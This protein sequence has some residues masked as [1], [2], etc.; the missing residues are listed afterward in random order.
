M[1]PVNQGIFPESGHKI[2]FTTQN[3][4]KTAVG[5]TIITGIFGPG[6]VVTVKPGVNELR[7]PTQPVG[8]DIRWGAESRID[9]IKPTLPERNPSA[10]ILV[11]FENGLRVDTA[12]PKKEASDAAC[13]CMEI[14]GQRFFGESVAVP[15]QVNGERAGLVTDEILD[16]LDHDLAGYDFTSRYEQL[17]TGQKRVFNLM[18]FG[19]ENG[20]DDNDETE[21]PQVAGFRQRVIEALKE[22]GVDDYWV[23]YSNGSLTRDKGLAQALKSA[24]SQF[25]NSQRGEDKLALAHTFKQTLIS[26][27]LPASLGGR[28]GQTVWMRDFGIMVNTL[29][30]QD[31]ARPGAFSA[32]LNSLFT[33]ASN[34]C[35]NGLIPQVVIPDQLLGEFIYLRALGGDSGPGW[36]NQLQAFLQ[37]NYPDAARRLPQL[38]A[39]ELRTLEPSVVKERVEGLKTLF[40]EISAKAQ[41]DGLPL[42]GPSH[43]LRG[44]LN[45]TLATL[46]PGTTDSEIHFIRSF[47]KLLDLADSDAQ[48]DQVKEMI[49]SLARAM[50]YLDQQV[51][52]PD[53]GLPQGSDNR[54]MLD[55][56][57]VQK[58]LCSNAC[59]LLQGFSGLVRHFDKI[60]SDLTMALNKHYQVG[61]E[62][63][64]RFISALM[65]DGVQAQQALE[66]FGQQIKN[67]FIYPEGK[68]APLDFVNSEH[69]VQR[70][71][72]PPEGY[73]PAL[74]EQNKDFLQGKEVNLQGLALAI[75]LGLVDQADHPAAVELIRSQLT[76]AG[77]KAFSP[78]NMGSDYEV[79]LLQKSQGFLV[80]PQIESRVIHVLKKQMDETPAIRDLLE[81]LETIHKQ[82][83]GFREWYNTTEPGG[84]HPGGAENQS[85]HITNLVQA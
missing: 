79:D 65:Q 3:Q 45:N 10:L 74:V 1:T 5:K 68:F 58:L 34:Q 39:T 70:Q 83:P 48:V 40:R 61:Q 59:F 12:S 50:V 21:T 20:I 7:T 71:P 29:N 63:A 11:S 75:E 13:V 76:G 38:D 52:D 43:T 30:Q 9:L 33:M 27:G 78:I 55:S 22:K 23:E 62:P 32:L 26:Q 56:Y 73:I 84:I 47:T 49:P 17:T 54:D 6:K 8:D 46:T 24:I 60:G 51:L 16:Y 31:T 82:R 25:I 67:T 18:V 28:Y 35:D 53:T 14:A 4:Q 72:I 81:Q 77:L 66:Q 19:H 80:W 44:F 15:V 41:E 37:A 57:L 69:M 42:P 64:S 85:W 36:Y 2:V